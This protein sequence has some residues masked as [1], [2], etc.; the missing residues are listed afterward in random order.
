[1]AEAVKT[2]LEFHRGR[3]YSRDF[4]ITDF[5]GPIDNILFT[6][7][8]NE[9]S[10]HYCIRKALDNGI[11]LVDEGVDE[12]GLNFK[13]YNLLIDAKDTDHLKAETDYGFDI[14]L[15]SGD[16]KYQLIEGTISLAG[17]Y[18]KACNEC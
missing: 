17:T 16:L 6:A 1:M 3:T 2:N 9:A 4:V 13:V 8:E 7:C 18:T 10:K 15:Y 14:V 12:E 11:S 5:N